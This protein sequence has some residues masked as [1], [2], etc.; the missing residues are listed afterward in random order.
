MGVWLQEASSLPAWCRC[1]SGCI[2]L[3]VML[4]LRL[5]A[6]RFSEMG[7]LCPSCDSDCSAWFEMC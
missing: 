4:G 7:M 2:L 6:W 5:S 3:S 1:Y